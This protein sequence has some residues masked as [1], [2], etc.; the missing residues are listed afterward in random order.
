MK[1][2]LELPDGLSLAFV[3]QGA[4][5]PVIFIP[6]WTYTTHVFARN[7][8]AFAARYRALAYDPRSHG[9]SS[10]TV[11]GNNFRQHGAD[12]HEFITRLGLDECILAGWSFGVCAAYSYVEQYGRARVRGFVSIDEPPRIRKETAADWGEG[13]Q[14]ELEGVMALLASQGHLKF[15]EEYLYHCYV[16]EP[17]PEF[18]QD[19][20]SEAAKT[21]APIAHELISNS[22][23]LDYREVARKLD[24]EMPVLQVVREDWRAAAGS[25][26][27]KNQPNASIYYMPAHLSF[28]EF[29]EEFNARVLAFCD[30]C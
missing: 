1:K 22:S 24:Q 25:W 11:D 18:V 26:I 7:L 17:G 3:E 28:H 5:R 6:G 10:V 2:R 8:P 27:S 23:D 9:D 4:G 12:L 15:F 20:L 29:A 16:N 14:E 19:M 21:P 13:M 30:G